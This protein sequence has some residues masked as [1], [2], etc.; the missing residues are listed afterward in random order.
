MERKKE[1]AALVYMADSALAYQALPVGRFG[2]VEKHLVNQSAV[3]AELTRPVDILVH[4]DT[5]EKAPGLAGTQLIDSTWKQLER[6]I[7]E[8]LNFPHT[9][10]AVEN[11]TEHIRYAQWMYSLHG[12][13]RWAEFCAAV[14]HFEERSLGERIASVSGSKASSAKGEAPGTDS[15]SAAV[16]LNAVAASGTVVVKDSHKSDA[17]GEWGGAVV[18]KDSHKSDDKPD[19]RVQTGGMHEGSDRNGDD[20]QELDCVEGAQLLCVPYL[21]FSSLLGYDLGCVS[22]QPP[23]FSVRGCV[24]AHSKDCYAIAMVRGLSC[25]KRV[26]RWAEQHAGRKACNR[27]RCTLCMLSDDLAQMA[28][29]G[30]PFLM[31]LVEHRATWSPEWTQARQ[32]CAMEAF[33]MLCEAC[34]GVDEEAARRIPDCI[35]HANTASGRTFPTFATFGGLLKSEL[36]CDFES[37]GRVSSKY[38]ITTHM[39]VT[40]PTGPDVTLEVAIDEAQGWEKLNKSPCPQCRNSLRQK[41][42]LMTAWPACLVVHIKRWTKGTLGHRW[43]KNNRGIS[44]EPQLSR[45]DKD[46]ILK[47]V[48]CHH[49]GVCSGHYICYACPQNAWY[50]C[51]DGVVAAC[52]WA[53]VL[54]DQAYILFYDSA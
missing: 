50:R 18:V 24:N 54:K 11:W 48:V 19:A 13:D 6:Y 5:R 23:S 31:K 47:A 29:P 39:Q 10:A 15:I 38:E 28:M 30:E 26:Q 21:D 49:G 41:R 3:P 43:V 42:L 51:D 44:F 2:I 16:A 20:T 35:E 4:V 1:D 17:S 45:G 52:T 12:K 25:I 32:E 37:C 7:P 22:K 27:D 53:D 14:Q 40:V 34:Q 9:L 8:S 33:Q 46:Y 36:R